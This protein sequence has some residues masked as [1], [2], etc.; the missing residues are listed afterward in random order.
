MATA[1]W[2]RPRR[3]LD[4][5]QNNLRSVASLLAALLLTS[6][7]GGQTGGETG[8]NAAEPQDSLGE[9]GDSCEADVTV[10]EPTELSPLGFS[11]ADL[12]ALVGE[13]NTVEL[14][15]LDTLPQGAEST[16]PP[17]AAERS[18]ASGYFP[19]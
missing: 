5:D 7:L 12:L 6:C 10:L 18:V 17:G 3:Q 19:T 14:Q 15:W 1:A 9:W 2:R 11:A 13:T 8:A 4:P 16:Q